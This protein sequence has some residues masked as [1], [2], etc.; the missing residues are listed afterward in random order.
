ML[1][2]TYVTCHNYNKVANVCA[3]YIVQKSEM[4]KLTTFTSLILYS[5]KTESCRV[6]L[7]VCYA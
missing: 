7:Q 2:V 1:P 3:S 6:I 5:G 4:Q